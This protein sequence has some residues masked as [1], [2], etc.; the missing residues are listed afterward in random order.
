MIER[1]AVL[2]AGTMGHG[3]AYVA[4]AAGY[5]VQLFDVSEGILEQAQSSI[6]QM[7]GKAV[8]RGELT[9]MASDEML[10]R[11]SGSTSIAEAVQHTD[12]IIEAV[13]E[14]IEVK[15]TT[16]EAVQNNAPPTAVLASNT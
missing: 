4:M 10:A 5:A 11:L 3:I 16:F 8:Q 13:P 12:L 2:G 15:L 14:R 6:R 9:A 7:A 1:I